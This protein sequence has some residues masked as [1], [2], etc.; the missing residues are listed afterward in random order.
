VHLE[1]SGE[2]LQLEF[3]FVVATVP[4][5]ESSGPPPDITYGLCTFHPYQQLFM[6]QPLIS[7]DA[8]TTANRQNAKSFPFCLLFCEILPVSQ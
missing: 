7:V 6:P 8:D 4:H 5:K 3:P 2:D 1:K